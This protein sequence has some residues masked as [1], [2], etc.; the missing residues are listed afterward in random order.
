MT[1]QAIRHRIAAIAVT[2]LLR[3]MA[4]LPLRGVHGCGVLVGSVL[5]WM[6][7]WNPWYRLI[8]AN[9]T[10][11]FPD[12]SPRQRTQLARRNLIETSKAFLEL[13]PLWHW[14]PDRVF[15]LICSVDGEATWRE[16][17]SLGRGGILVTPHLGAW[18]L[19]GLYL[20]R[21]TR[22]TV[23]YRPSRQGALLDQL[24][25]RGRT[26]FGARAVPTTRAGVRALRRALQAGET[27]GLM[28]DQHPRTMGSVIAPFFGQ[29]VATMTLAVKL[30]RSCQCPIFLIT[31]I[32][33]P[34][35]RGYHLSFTPLPEVVTAASLEAAVAAL[36]AA[37]ER[38]IRAHPDQ[39]L[40]AYRHLI[41]RRTRP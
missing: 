9:L 38:A 32:R 18:E 17:L 35:G 13:G 22:F 7:G 1:R 26:R 15:G 10:R 41:Q 8:V 36:N 24:S 37:I 40:W 29:P 5:G 4:W 16:A 6:P 2:G 33:L 25:L 23:L 14:P 20:P 19:I 27:I 31:A 28:P 11:C 3:F 21:A 34:K 30:A 12:Q 39:Y